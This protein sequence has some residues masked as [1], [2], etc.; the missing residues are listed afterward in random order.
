M[1]KDVL[2]GMLCNHKMLQFLPC[3]AIELQTCM[4]AHVVKCQCSACHM[5]RGCSNATCMK[6]LIPKET[7][8][9]AT[10]GKQRR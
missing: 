7:S 1:V 5:L 4:V 2:Q 6:A 8:E 9:P 10:H 3:L